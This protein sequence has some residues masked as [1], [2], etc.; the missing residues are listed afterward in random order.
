MRKN[1]PLTEGGRQQ[2]SGSQRAP[3]LKDV[4]ERL[5]DVYVDTVKQA[6]ESDF[7]LKRYCFTFYFEKYICKTMSFS[8]LGLISFG[9]SN[10]SWMISGGSGP[11]S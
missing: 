9:F 1:R 7:L 11:L 2:A 4:A 3:Y 8:S 6:P 10:T 5:L